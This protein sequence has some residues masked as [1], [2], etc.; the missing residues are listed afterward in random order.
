MTTKYKDNR[1][2]VL[3]AQIGLNLLTIWTSKAPKTKPFLLCT[4][5]L[6]PKESKTS[7]GSVKDKDFKRKVWKGS[8][9]L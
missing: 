2:R 4:Q 5:L 8:E 9:K 6:S 7:T 3:K 1:F